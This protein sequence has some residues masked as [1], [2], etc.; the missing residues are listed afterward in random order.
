MKQ[1]FKH[2]TIL[3]Y[4]KH[5]LWIPVFLFCYTISIKAQSLASDAIMA[6]HRAPFVF[7][8]ISSKG[9][10][11]PVRWGIDTAWLWDW[12]PLRATN[13]MRE[14]VSLGRVTLSPRVNGSYTELNAE[15]ISNFEL[16]LSWLKKSGVT[17]LYLLA[18][19]TS[20]SHWQTSY[21][22]A[23]IKDIEL[24]VEKNIL[25]IALATLPKREQEI[26]NMRYGFD[27]DKEMTQKEVAD[28]LDI[29]Q[30]Y[31]SRLEKK[32]ISQLKKE[33]EK[34]A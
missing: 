9:I 11:Q 4:N 31:I 28:K 7:Y 18:G 8:N 1:L 6:P 5:L 25:H 14:C 26:M 29:S 34:L 21:R 20:G 10:E 27:N 13:H 30:S 24:S 19:N 32:I 3:A 22:S 2:Q 17:D 16:Q 12:W 23:F 15:Q 33:M